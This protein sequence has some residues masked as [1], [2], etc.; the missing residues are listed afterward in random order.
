MSL[1]AFSSKGQVDSLVTYSVKI[2][3][4]LYLAG[5]MD[6]HLW[7]PLCAHSMYV[8]LFIQHTYKEPPW[9]RDQKF[10][11]P[12]PVDYCAK[13][14]KS[15]QEKD[16]ASKGTKLDENQRSAGSRNYHIIQP[17]SKTSGLWWPSF[18]AG[19]VKADRQQK[20]TVGQ[21][22]GQVVQQKWK[23]VLEQTKGSE[24]RLVSAPG[25]GRSAE[26]KPTML[27]PQSA[28]V[29]RFAPL[30]S[31]EISGSVV[32]LLFLLKSLLNLKAL[33]WHLKSL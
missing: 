9:F 21:Q 22:I 7:N 31:S 26:A 2:Y 13:I 32:Y 3:T 11:L 8:N 4:R 12:S 30:L 19:S 20:T 29:P 14:S 5:L 28:S 27:A 24:F 33:L 1:F 6:Q 25:A 10:I 23:L 18:I 16:L 17:S 15:H